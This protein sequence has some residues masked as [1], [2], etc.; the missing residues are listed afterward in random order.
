LISHFWTPADGS[1]LNEGMKRWAANVIWPGKGMT[2]GDAACMGVMLD[3][4]PIAC[5]LFHNWEPHTGVIE[6]SAASVNRR[7]IT[8]KTLSA[9]FEYPFA[10]A[11]AQML[12]TRN[13]SGPEQKHLHRMLKSYGF[14]HWLIPRLGGR[15]KDMLLWTLTDD[16]WR[17]SHFN[18]KA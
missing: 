3:D 4:K 10:T 7:W 13:S 9:M 15:D 1:E 17:A 16:Q 11:G 12:V 2:F 6:M 5:V 14:V 8:R 18:A